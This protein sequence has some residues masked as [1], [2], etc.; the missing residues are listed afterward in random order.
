MNQITLK[1]LKIPQNSPNINY[2]DNPSC[3]S[4]PISTVAIHVLTQSLID[5]NPKYNPNPNTSLDLTL[6]STQTT[7]STKKDI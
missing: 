2:W 1:Y 5:V 3:N 4:N 7:K 6:I